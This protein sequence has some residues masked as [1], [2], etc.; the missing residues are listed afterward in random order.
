MKSIS[1]LSI[2]IL[3]A[4]STLMF[5]ENGNQPSVSKDIVKIENHV[6][7]QVAELFFGKAKI[8]VASTTVIECDTRYPFICVW[9]HEDRIIVNDGEL[10]EIY[11][12]SYDTEDLGNGI[13]EIT[14]IE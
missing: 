1:F 6:D 13:T 9:I 14:I 3:L 5:A 10:T 8:I 12:T 11:Y 2:A 7:S 4:F